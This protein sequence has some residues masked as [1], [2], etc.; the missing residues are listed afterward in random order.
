MVVYV[1]GNILLVLHS[2]TEQQ[3]KGGSYHFTDLNLAKM[4]AKLCL[5]KD[6][7]HLQPHACRLKPDE[8]LFLLI[9]IQAFYYMLS[10]MR[11]CC[12]IIW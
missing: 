6:S 10:I 3:A 7:M 2:S 11:G 1:H 9:K 8:N 4:R 12:G 5:V